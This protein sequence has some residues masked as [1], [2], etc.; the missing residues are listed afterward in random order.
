MASGLLDPEFLIG[1]SLADNR[2]KL[3][4]KIGAG[5][6]AIVYRAFDH[7]LETEVVVK[8][9]K[10]QKLQDPGL[11]ERFRRES[12]LLVQLQHPHIVRILDVGLHG[13]VPYVVMQYLSGGCLLDRMQ[14]K[15]GQLTALRPDSVRTWLLE[16]AKALDFAHQQKVVHRDVKPANILFD[17]AGNA[18]LGDFGL[19]KMM[20][21][22]PNDDAADETAAGF[23]VGTPN[24]VAPEI[25]LGA[26]Y[27][28]RADQYSL[29]ISVYNTLI[30][31]PPMLGKTPSAT[32][33]NQTRKILPLLNEVR[34]SVPM[35][36]SIALAKALNKKPGDRFS[37]C[38]EFAEAVIAGLT[39][40]GES[41]SS[42][43]TASASTSSAVAPALKDSSTKGVDSTAKTRASAT[44]TNAARDNATRE[45]RRR[46]AAEVDDDSMQ[47]P[48]LRGRVSKAVSPGVI[49]C[50]QCRKV[51]NLRK[52][53][54][55]RTGR[56]VQCKT[57][58]RIAANLGTLTTIDDAGWASDSGVSSSA[59]SATDLIIGE[60]VFGFK[61]SK[62]AIMGLAI[63]LIVVVI[64]CTALLVSQWT[65]P[66]V[67][68]KE[69]EIL[70]KYQ[71]R[72]G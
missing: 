12:R 4:A 56:C 64:V 21:G 45:K 19:T 11:M 29:A 62:Q 54:A 38:V 43:S 9:P 46:K 28:G 7:R 17:E 68:K 13:N 2:F 24:F 44:S 58:L 34:K 27:D 16:V 31:A 70:Q 14:G 49:H 50:P 32:M 71:N 5:S 41:D 18:F 57:R 61:F 40:T 42:S 33:V 47:M 15:T 69:Q 30:G 8:V 51:L 55:G 3:V 1:A 35:A 25:V 23:V 65:K 60:K 72:E 37:T 20:H 59:S 26:E 52:E 22:E 67:E 6:M 48:A 39:A 66:D 53:H 63:G 10:K 36:T